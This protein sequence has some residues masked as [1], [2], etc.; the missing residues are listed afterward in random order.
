MITDISQITSGITALSNLALVT[1][2][3]VVGYQPMKDPRTKGGNALVFNYEGENSIS[4]ESDITDHAIDDNSMVQDHIG[5]RP[6]IITVQGFVGELNDIVPYGL[7]TAAAAVQS[8]L[9]ALSAYAPAVTNAAVLAFNE[10]FFAYQLAAAAATSAVSAY[11]SITNLSSG[12]SATQNKQQTMFNQFYAYWKARTLFTIQTP[13]AIFQN[14]A[15]LRMRTIQDADTQLVST[16]EI[17][18][19]P[20]KFV[21]TVTTIA[22]TTTSD[23]YD[24]RAANQAAIEVSRGLQPVGPPTTFSVA[25]VA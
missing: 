19:K 24:G 15:I 18:F 8:K 13:W 10:A 7:Q 21:N 9:S 3:D 16:F 23:N 17:Q 20:L 4:L 14:C 25:G 6:E 12:A 5:L 1:P 2:L 22:P 11:S